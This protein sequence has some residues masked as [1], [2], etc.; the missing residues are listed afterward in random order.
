MI[1][2]RPLPNGDVLVTFTIKDTRPVSVVGD[3][4]DWDP[5]RHPLVDE[6]DSQRSITVAVPPETTVAFR[7]LADGGDFYDDPNADRYEPN[8]YGQTHSV[9]DASLHVDRAPSAAPDEQLATDAVAT[10]N[11]QTDG[12]NKLVEATAK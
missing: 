2:T 3:F 1:T 8:G 5:T 9:L 7:Y 4:N 12:G 10:R 11:R 6:G